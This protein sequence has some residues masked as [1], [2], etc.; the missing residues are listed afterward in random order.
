MPFLGDPFFG[1]LLLGSAKSNRG[2]GPV[3]DEEGRLIPEKY[4]AGLPPE[5]RKARI[6]E[7]TASRSGE[8]GFEELPTDVAARQLGITKKGQYT[9]E[10]ERRGLVHKG[11]YQDTARRA[12]RYYGISPSEKDV[13]TV[14]SELEKV[15]KKGLAAWQTG[16]HRPGASQQAWAFARVH[17]VLVG[18]KAA[19]TADRKNVA[20]FP[21]ALREA[22]HAQRMFR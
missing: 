13:R 17:S 19:Y 10:A 12:F 1:P 7:L 21:A 2:K 4:L 16:G 6:Q 9:V 22:I 5:L 18:G 3:Y 20:Q 11:D 14:A 8:R 15:F